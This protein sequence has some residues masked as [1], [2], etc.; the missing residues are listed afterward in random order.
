ML[1]QIWVL[2][3]PT[4]GGEVVKPWKCEE[5]QSI[6]CHWFAEV[7]LSENSVPHLPNGFAARYPY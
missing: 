5:G 3:I 1:C 7:G 4:A 2:H 6:C